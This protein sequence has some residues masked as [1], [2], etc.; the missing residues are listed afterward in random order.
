M[1]QMHELELG[2]LWNISQ[3]PRLYSSNWTIY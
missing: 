3:L 1:L 2:G